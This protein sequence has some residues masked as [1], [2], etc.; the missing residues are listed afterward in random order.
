MP[1]GKQAEELRNDYDEI[2]HLIASHN[3]K[4]WVGFQK[5]RAQEF[6]NKA[7]QFLRAGNLS[8]AQIALALMS[9]CKKQ[10]TSFLEAHNGLRDQIDGGK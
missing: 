9:E 3:W 7:N 6:Q 8:E 4:H 10:I 5:K 1:S 2:T